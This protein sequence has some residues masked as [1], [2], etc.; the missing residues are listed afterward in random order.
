MSLVCRR[1]EEP[2]DLVL[3][4]CCLYAGQEHSIHVAGMVDATIVPATPRETD[5]CYIQR[6]EQQLSRNVLV[7]TPTVL[8]STRRSVRCVKNYPNP[9]PTT[10]QYPR[11]CF[12]CAPLFEGE[13]RQQAG[14]DRQG[15][16]DRP[17]GHPQRGGEAR[18]PDEK[19]APR[20]PAAQPRLWG[21][22]QGILRFLGVGIHG[23][24]EWGGCVLDI[25]AFTVPRIFT[26]L[27]RL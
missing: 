3:G 1:H 4:T 13:R 27:K 16:G 20:G 15:Q 17:R 10:P 7:L 12:S 22:G 2:R 23:A 26:S 6:R 21:P 18:S 14:G 9:C 8:Y 24:P 25:N 11:F 19:F 5:I